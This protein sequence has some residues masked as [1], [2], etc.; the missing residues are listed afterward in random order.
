MSGPRPRPGKR[1]SRTTRWPRPRATPKTVFRAA[2]RELD[3]L[4]H[5][6]TGFEKLAA[7]DARGALES[8]AQAKDLGPNVLSEAQFRAGDPAKAD[9]T[10]RDTQQK[11]SRLAHRVDLLY[12][13]GKIDEARKLFDQLRPLANQAPLDLPVFQRLRPAVESWQ[14]PADWRQP[15]TDPGDLGQRPPL[16]ELGPF[17]WQPWL[18]ADWKLTDLDGKSASLAEYRGKP[19]VAIFYLGFGCIHCVEQLNAFS[20]LAEKFRA[21]GIEPIA[22]STD[23]LAAMRESRDQADL[24]QA[25]RIFSDESL[26]A[27]KAYRAYDDFEQ[28]PLHGAFLIDAAGLIRWQDISYKPF[29]DPAFL[30]TESQRLLALPPERVTQ[31]AAGP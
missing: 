9:E 15:R 14:L 12:R 17:R 11:L 29:T 8:F 24:K 2:S 13:C 19:L 21:A 27:F 18:A 3:E 4:R 5:E 22:I 1:K 10:S 7:G 25:L 16:D 6:L 30:L 28:K 31:A 23:S 20:P 26:E